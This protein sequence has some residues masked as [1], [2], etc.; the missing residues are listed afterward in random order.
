MK[1]YV[2]TTTGDGVPGVLALFTKEAEA[3][4][5]R[6]QFIRDDWDRE[7]PC[8]GDDMPL[9]FPEGDVVKAAELIQDW[10]NGAYEAPQLS[11]HELAA[12][13][14]IVWN[15]M[16]TA[17]KDRPVIFACPWMHPHRVALGWW[18]RMG[19]PGW[20]LCVGTYKVHQ[21]GARALPVAWAEFPACPTD[22]EIAAL[23]NPAPQEQNQ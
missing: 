12:P 1:I 18:R 16:S 13:P 21:T 23:Y 19:K 15:P 6:L 3:N 14:G 9:E 5:A 2:L 10:S 8:G 4:A 7:N 22:E 20:T 11:T 17:P